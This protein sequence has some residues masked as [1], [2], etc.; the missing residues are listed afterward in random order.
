MA[1]KNYYTKEEY[2]MQELVQK[3]ID[4]AGFGGEGFTEKQVNQIHEYAQMVGDELRVRS[5]IWNIAEANDRSDQERITQ[6]MDDARKEV[7]IYPDRNVGMSALHGY[8]YFADDMYPLGKEQAL[9]LHRRGLKVYCLQTDGSKSE[10]ASREMIQEH[11]GL[12]G[13]ERREWD[14]LE[15]DEPDYTEEFDSLR[16]P[17]IIVN[18]EEALKYYDAGA[19]IYLITPFSQPIAASERT[20]IER[21]SDYFQLPEDEQTL[22]KDLEAE[23]KEHP[24]MQSLKEARLL[25]GNEKRYGIYQFKEGSFAETYAFMNMNYIM[26]HNIIIRK[27][28]YDLVYSGKMFINDSLDSLYERF[29]IDRPNDFTGHSMSVGDIIVV[30]DGEKLASYFVDSV[31]FKELDH[32]IDMEIV[33]P[34]KEQE[35]SLKEEYKPLTK[36]EELEEQNYNMVDNVLNNGFGEKNRREEI[37]KTA[38]EYQQKTGATITFFAAVCEEFPS[39]GDYFDGL[40]IE[41][42]TDKYEKILED[43]RLGYMG[44]GMGLELHDP[45]LPDYLDGPLTLI[46]GRTIY[47]DNI[48]SISYYREH[49]LVLEAV[50]QLKEHF[51]N[52]KYFMTT[53]EKQDIYPE[54]MTAESIAYALVD[55]AENFETYEFHDNVDN[56]ETLVK[57]IEYN[58]YAGLGK[59]E[60]ASF[61]K[62]VIDESDELST[63]AQILLQR[64]NG[65]SIP[66]KMDLEPLVK[67]VSSEYREMETGKYLPFKEANEKLGILDQNFLKENQATDKWDDLYSVEYMVLCSIDSQIRRVNGKI[68]LGSGEGDIIEHMKGIE[69]QRDVQEH[70]L[71]YLYEYCG[72][73]EKSPEIA[74]EVKETE[75]GAVAHKDTQPVG[76]M[77]KSPV[78]SEGEKKKSIHDRLKENKKN[79]GQKLGKD[80]PQKGVELT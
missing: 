43:P 66:E 54:H 51:P 20:E 5:L 60:Y 68:M 31:S 53:Q 21:G 13:V 48:D 36:V 61:L 22:L 10:Y 72:L 34:E 37:R 50:Q 70:I 45:T 78:K 67:I 47:A 38:E 3:Q 77:E 30:N 57:E 18:K 12:F 32:F 2:E 59:K 9:D 71:P 17:M 41:Q 62:D 28:D 19:T 46:K 76:I 69:D 63:K 42:A 40:T 11:E 7:E 49:P 55:L 14:A 79:L 75:T 39:M 4:L 35:E 1:L 52:F 80:D 29:N 65:Y 64:I 16:D 24:Q 73:V 6:L 23:M 58:L 25:L 15:A 27:E 44:N 33:L 8:G 74:A 26:D 56:K